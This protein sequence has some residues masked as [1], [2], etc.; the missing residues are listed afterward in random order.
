MESGN[1]GIGTDLSQI[2]E[3]R[4][5][6]YLALTSIMGAG[7]IWFVLLNHDPWSNLQFQEFM[8]SILFTES[9]SELKN[10]L[11]VHFWAAVG[12]WGFYGWKLYVRLANRDDSESWLPKNRKGWANFL[13]ERALVSIWMSFLL[14]VLLAA[15][16]V[17]EINIYGAV[18]L[19]I[20]A[21]QAINLSMKK[22]SES[23]KD[24]LS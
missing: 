12:M 14:L 24:E 18:L 8:K 23:K 4:F 7:F 19:G 3:P 21:P 10:Y 22:A 1:K 17:T 13:V 9:L 16:R 2:V 5:T 11:S 20:Y 6:S 15:I